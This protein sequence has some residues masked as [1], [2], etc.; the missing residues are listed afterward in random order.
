MSFF[1]WLYPGMRVK[2][3]LVLLFLGMMIL[4]LGAAY[5]MANIY[6]EQPFP[7]VF[8]YLTLQFVPRIF[9]ALLFGVVGVATTSI[10]VV[11]LNRSLLSA[12]VTEGDKLVDRIY[13]RR[14]LARGPKV[15]AIGGGTG[16]SNL[17]RGLKEFTGNIT[18]IVTVADDGGSS[19]RLRSELGILPPGDFRQCIVALSDVEPLMTKLFQYRFGEGSGLEG[20]SFGNLFI[21]AMLGV[22][23]NF[24]NALR[25][26][27]RV[28]ATRGQILPSTLTNVTLCAELTGGQIVRGESHIGHSGKRI[29]RVFLQPDHVAAYPAAVRAIEEADLVVLGPGSLFTSVL[30][31]LL[32]DGVRAA[33]QRTPALVIYVCNVATEEGETDNYTVG[34]HL[35]TIEQYLD[36]GAVDLVLA[37]EHRGRNLPV[38]A[39]AVS[40]VVNGIASAA[41]DHRLV[42][43]DVVDE[44]NP[45]HHHSDH[46][47]ESII[48]LYYERGADRAPRAAPLL[49]GEERV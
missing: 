28:L 36:A 12:F 34:Q 49:K 22:T 2:R 18:A 24:E 16:L 14:Q 39:R 45:R 7:W 38:N 27:S 37:N 9:R 4:S 21:A 15:V 5:V 11:Q 47:A 10:A 42:K 13:Q 33:I 44:H 17:L 43:A 3:W 31:N 26:S 41:T 46:L 32:V 1:K 29:E 19:G 40:V 6:R 25:E 20:H 23:G 8:Y 48:R 30:P 35:A